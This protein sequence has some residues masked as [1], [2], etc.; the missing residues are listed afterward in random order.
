MAMDIFGKLRE[1]GY[2]TCPEDFYSHIDV[3]KSWYDGDVDKFHHYRVWNG[4]KKLSCSRYGLGMAKKVCEDWANLLMNEKV[5]ITLEG[6]A[7]QEFFDQVCTD[8]NFEVKANELEELT[9][10]GGTTA[11]VVRA[12]DVPINPTS[13][14]VTGSGKLKLDYVYMPNIYPLS[15]ENGKVN[16]CAFATKKVDGEDEYMYV[17]IHRRTENGTYDIENY[18]YRDN[19]GSLTN[20]PLDTIDEYADVAE[21]ISTAETDRLFVINRPNIVNNI[22]PS[23]PLGISVYANAIDQLKGVDIAYDTYVNEFVLG[24]KRVIVKAEALQNN[25]GEPTFDPDDVV[26]YALPEDSSAGTEATIIKE[27][28]MSLRTPQLNE[29]VQDMLNVLSSKCGFGESHYKYNRGSVATATQ[30]VSENS[31]LFRT[32]KKHEIVLEEM[33]KELVRIILRMGNTYCG[34]SLNTDVEVSIDFDD[35]IIEDKNTEFQRDCALVS[36]GCMNLYEFR[37]KWMNED[38]DTAKAALPQM[39]ELVQDETE[40][41]TPRKARAAENQEE[42]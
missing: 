37:M 19:E 41:T 5:K 16:E 23:L 15:W 20:V 32:I 33:L 7:E 22:D 38:E 36:M 11:I 42:Q 34:K 29:G 26:F 39:E 3:W 40:S 14:T 28:D 24:K 21:K 2:K 18:L 17:Q 8:N 30:I 10:F 9:F 25:D 27:L 6:D 31:T 4:Q 35:S 1:L 12:V 13:G